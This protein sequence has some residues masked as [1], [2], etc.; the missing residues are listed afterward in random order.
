M[1]A[2]RYLFGDLDS[3]QIIAELPLTGVSMEMKLNDW[4]IFR[5]TIHYDTSGIDNADIVAATTPGRSFLVVERE[6]VPVWDGIVWTSVYNSDAKV[7]N[8][9]ARTYEAYADA[10]LIDVDFSRTAAEQRNI[11]CDL[12]SQLQSTNARNLSINV[13]AAFSTLVPRDLNVL[14]SEYKTFFQV[15]SSISDGNNGFD[16]SISTIKQNNL[17][18]RSIRVGYPFLGTTDG[19]A[20]S[21]DYPG[22]VTNYYKT[23]GMSNAGTNL[24]LL[25][26]GEGSDM[27]VSSVVQA[28]LIASGFKRFDV[29]IP[30]K[31][32][33]DQT[34][35]DSLAVQL[36]ALRRPPISVIKVFLKADLDPVFGSYGLGDSATVS[37][38][39]PR[40]PSGFTTT[41]RIVAIAY[42]PQSNDGVEAA[43]LIFQ[44]DD[45]ND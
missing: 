17:Y 41:A 6:D 3:R 39:D 45:L 42:N 12:W 8:I 10:N 37:I 15:M 40:H 44:G 21:F 14:A 20:L 33:E 24:F 26:A 43:E 29:A 38:T 25:G 36:G 18:V 13:P 16:W 35:L 22:N 34:Q 11:F 23:S 31:D 32:I 7:Q 4:G 27:V 1:V 30:R 28:D 5:G 19:S 9:T 2:V